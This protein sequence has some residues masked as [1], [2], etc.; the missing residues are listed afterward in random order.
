MGWPSRVCPA[1]TRPTKEEV[2]S[3]M[4]QVPGKADVAF[5]SKGQELPTG[6]GKTLFTVPACVDPE[7]VTAVVAPFRAPLLNLFVRYDE[8]LW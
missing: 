4:Q 3:A 6:G 2:R 8:I 7:G 5:R 1:A